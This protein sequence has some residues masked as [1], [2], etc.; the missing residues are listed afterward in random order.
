MLTE[1]L[2]ISVVA[3]SKCVREFLYLGDSV[4]CAM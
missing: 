2:L 1:M 3:V 4:S